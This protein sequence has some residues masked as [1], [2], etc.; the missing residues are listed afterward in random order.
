MWLFFG[1][2]GLVL[3]SREAD[4]DSAELEDSVGVGTETFCS[5]EYE[6]P[7]FGRDPAGC[8]CRWPRSRKKSAG[9]A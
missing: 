1:G 5:L 3:P 2:V 8:A 4:G 9:I 7:D 6:V